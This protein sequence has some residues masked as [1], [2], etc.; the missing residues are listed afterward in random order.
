ME[1]TELAEY[2]ASRLYEGYRNYCKV[3]GRKLQSNAAGRLIGTMLSG[4]SFQLGG[5]PLCPGLQLSYGIGLVFDELSQVPF[6]DDIT[7]HKSAD[8]S[9]AHPCQ[10]AKKK[11]SRKHPAFDLEQC[12]H[13]F[14]REALMRRYL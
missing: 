2:P 7:E 12:Y 10:Q 13:L 6:A 9:R 4:L 8:L 11:G 3:L 1:R 14:I 5:L